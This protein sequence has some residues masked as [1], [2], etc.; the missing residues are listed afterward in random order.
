[1]YDDAPAVVAGVW[2]VAENRG[3]QFD[4]AAAAEPLELRGALEA[5]WC[6]VGLLVKRERVV[7]LVVR[8]DAVVVA[9]RVRVGGLLR[10][11]RA[12]ALEFLRVFLRF[13]VLSSFFCLLELALV[14]EYARVTEI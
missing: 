11:F 5:S 9:V 3:A 7:G 2:S 10:R 14:P 6:H 8:V 4:G 12:Q 13:V 1:M